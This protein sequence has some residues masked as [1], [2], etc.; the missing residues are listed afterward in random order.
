MA[1]AR[2]PIQETKQMIMTMTPHTSKNVVQFVHQI[3]DELWNQPVQLR[4]VR[5]KAAQI[6]EYAE[7]AI[8]LR[9]TLGEVF[10]TVAGYYPLPECIALYRRERE[11]YHQHVATGTSIG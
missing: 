11:V 5:T 7:G 1:A 10:G 8:L 4:D 9:S 6:E 2:M 3:R